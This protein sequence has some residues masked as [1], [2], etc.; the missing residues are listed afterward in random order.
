M[1]FSILELI[2]AILFVLGLCKHPTGL[3]FMGLVLLSFIT[4]RSMGSF[5]RAFAEQAWHTILH[6]PTFSL[7]ACS[8]ALYVLRDNDT[9]WSL[10]SSKPKLTSNQRAGGPAQEE[11]E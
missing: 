11:R 3:I 7:F 8:V 9:L 5:V 1:A 10:S 6:F 2:V 4:P